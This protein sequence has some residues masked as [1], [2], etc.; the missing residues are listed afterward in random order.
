[1]EQ[2]LV[3]RYINGRIVKGK[4]MNFNP[5]APN[6]LIHWLHN[7]P[8][9]PPLQV[10]LSEVKAIFFVRDFAGNR[11]YKDRQN[12]KPG[13]PYQGRRM[14]LDLS[15]GESMVGSSPNYA[16]GT[17]GF[18]FFPADPESNMLKAWIPASSIRQ[19]TFLS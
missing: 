12:F 15:D 5:A 14:K 18:F 3:V 8:D 11:L 19:V 10:W 7:A 4:T 1:M 9:A 2:K 6:F 13:D 16:P 17:P